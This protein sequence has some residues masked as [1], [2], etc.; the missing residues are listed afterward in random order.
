MLGGSQQ[1]IAESQNLE[2]VTVEITGGMNEMASCADQINVAV[3]RVNTVS[4]Q[5]KESIEL[6]VP[7]VSKFKVD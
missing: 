4:A 1:I 7:E 5:N 6:L 3:T 2:L